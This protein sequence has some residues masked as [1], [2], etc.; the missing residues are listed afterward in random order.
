MELT[1]KTGSEND[2]LLNQAFD[3]TQEQ[4][5][6]PVATFMPSKTKSAMQTLT[7]KWRC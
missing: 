2:E 5:F 4:A 1:G 6:K 7:L 3:K